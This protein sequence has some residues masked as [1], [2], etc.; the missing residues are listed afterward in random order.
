MMEAFTAYIKT[1]SALTVFSVAVG[2][3]MPKGNF[4]QYTRWILGLL[5]LLAVLKPMLGLFRLEEMDFSQFFALPEQE[6]S[7]DAELGE[8]WTRKTMENQVLS[9][10]QR[11]EQNVDGVHIA[12]NEES[13]LPEEMEISGKNLPDSLKEDVAKEYGMETEA[14]TLVP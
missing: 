6:V 9:E 2:L 14:V 4:R 11:Q 3:L 13:G 8:N 12:W 1:I 10:L 5:V 7:Y